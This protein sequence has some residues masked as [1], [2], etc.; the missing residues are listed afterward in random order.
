M[1]RIVK[2]EA[3][4]P[5]VILYEICLLYTSEACSQV[6]GE[7]GLAAAGAA[8]DA[9]ENGVHSRASPHF[10]GSFTTL[11]AGTCFS[12]PCFL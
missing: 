11:R 12:R 9:D 7:R 10:S 2:K 1:Y 6:L 4:K 8:G 3:L 5:T